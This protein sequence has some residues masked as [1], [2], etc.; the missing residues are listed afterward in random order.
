MPE[1]VYRRGDCRLCASRDLELVVQ[2]E[3]TPLADQYVPAQRL[4]HPQE[5]YPLDLF[6]CRG[7]GHVQL[8]DVV[9]PEAI[10]DDY[11]Y[12]TSNSLGLPQ[13]FDGYAQ[14]VMNHVNPADGGLVVDIGSNDGTLL[15]S[16]QKRGMRVLGIDPAREIALKATDAGV[17]TL[18]Y[19]FSSRMAFQLREERGPAAVI[20]SNNLM[21]NVDDLRDLS[22]GVLTMLAPDGVWVFETGYLAD[23]VQKTI[24][25]NIFHEHMDY[26]S[27]VPLEAF[28]SSQGMELVDVQRVDTKGGSLRGTV[29]ATGGP[30]S[31]SPT[32]GEF[33]DSEVRLGLTRPETYRKFASRL[34]SVKLQLCDML[35]SLQRQ[36]KSIAGYGAS[37]SVTTLIYHFGLGSTLEFLVDDN[38]IKQGLFS[39][40]HH[41][42]VFPPEAIYQHQPDYMVVLP[43]RF[44]HPIVDQH[45]AYLKQGGHFIVPLPQ[46]RVI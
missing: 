25:D 33:M 15:R 41:L 11:I 45:Q 10:Y 9:S 19:F 20:T 18:A 17:E 43:W 35:S 21:A 6:L 24:F 38:P 8:L 46:V 14:S 30:L 13:H 7:C 2:L 5:T 16:F 34:D 12:E 22:A 26:H 44:A 23:L 42:P 39:P 1:L 37:H 32:V 27:V 40:G 4:E 29:Q 3:P 28:F 36:G 31:V